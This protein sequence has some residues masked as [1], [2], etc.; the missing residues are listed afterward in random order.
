MAIPKKGSFAADETENIVASNNRRLGTVTPRRTSE[1]REEI[2]L[3]TPKA[4][5]TKLVPKGRD[6]AWLMAATLSTPSA[7]RS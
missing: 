4:T 7:Y 6:M 2:T 3:E 5:V 1:I